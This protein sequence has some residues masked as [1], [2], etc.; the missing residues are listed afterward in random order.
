MESNL[1]IKEVLSFYLEAGIDE[2]I[3]DTAGFVLPEKEEP[4]ARPAIT[5]MAQ[6]TQN[7]SKNA[8]EA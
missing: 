1:N 5:N 8:K 2:T 7:A 3:G 4:K 6:S